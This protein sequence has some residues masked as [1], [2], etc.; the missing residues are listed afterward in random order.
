[1]RL[2]AQWKQVVSILLLE[3]VKLRVMSE[4]AGSRSCIFNANKNRLPR[5]FIVLYEQTT[6]LNLVKGSFF[7]DLSKVRN[8]KQV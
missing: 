5:M 2:R 1:M 3:K 7:P 6:A 4:V 8:R